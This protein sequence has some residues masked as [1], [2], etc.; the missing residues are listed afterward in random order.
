MTFVVVGHRGALGIEP[1]N[2]LRSFRRAQELGVD[3]IELDLH[4]SQDGYLVIS[5]D[6]DV[7]RA[8]DG[9]G[10]IAEKTLEE[11]RKLDAG[12]GERIPTF[13]EA[14]DVIEIPIQ[15]E[16]KA[17]DAAYRTV[18]TLVARDLLDRVIVTS[19]H[20]DAI[21]AAK[22]YNPDVRTGF[23]MSAAPPDCVEQATALGAHLLCVGIS[24]LTTDIV[25]AAH[26]AGL[27]VVGWTVNVPEQVLR[28][29]RLGVDRITTDYPRVLTDT[30]QA[31]PEI[32]TAVNDLERALHT[33]TD[34]T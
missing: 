11:L 13:D 26:S 15:A 31:I 23:I 30:A 6:A 32:R 2:T 33:P 5:H 24:R 18:D 12:L 19:F 8:T 1:E 34:Q 20:A 9:T 27:L 14:L 4:L 28:A 29:Y 17:L 7:D 16:V 3:E 10:A 21:R 25:D 22:A